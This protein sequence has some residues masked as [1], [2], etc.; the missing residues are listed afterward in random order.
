MIEN[1]PDQRRDRDRL[2]AGRARRGRS[3]D[4]QEVGDQRRP[5]RAPALEDP[6][7]AEVGE[8]GA[9]EPE[10]DDGE[11]RL[12][13]RDDRQRV[14]GQRTRARRSRAGRRRPGTPPGSL[15]AARGCCASRRRCRRR[16]RSSRR[17]ARARRACCPTPRSVTSSPTR[18]AT[19]MKPTTSPARRLTVIV[20]PCRNSA[21]MTIT[22]SGTA[23]LITDASDESTVCSANVIRLNGIAML[24]DAHD[25]QVAVRP[26][27]ARQRLPGDRH[28]RREQDEADQEP[29]HDQRE[30][31]EA[32][33]DADLDEQVAAAPEEA[34]GEEDQPVDSGAAGLPWVPMIAICWP[35]AM[36]Q[37]AVA[38]RRSPTGTRRPAPPLQDGGAGHSRSSPANLPDHGMIAGLRMSGLVRSGGRRGGGMRLWGGRFAADAT[39]RSRRSAARST[40]MRSS[41]STTSTARSPT[42]AGW[43]GPGS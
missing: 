29:E 28:D 39:S 21:A 6:E 32:V 33:V 30:R 34:E 23:P 41:R 2:A 18:I 42:S 25:E 19:P 43:A 16:T 1:G 4:R 35:S 31:L 24:I 40:S 3:R 8:A 10:P 7:V 12:G 20:S 15:A 27:V 14:L 17:S 5:G 26:R 36:G 13:R 11:D 22:N 38:A 37:A 9:E